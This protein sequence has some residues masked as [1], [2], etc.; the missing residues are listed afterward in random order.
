MVSRCRERLI[1]NTLYSQVLGVPQLKIRNRHTK[2]KKSKEMHKRNTF[3]H[4]LIVSLEMDLQ[5]FNGSEGKELPKGSCWNL[6]ESPDGLIL[7]TV[8]LEGIFKDHYSNYILICSVGLDS[9]EIC[10]SGR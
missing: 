9:E 8:Q 6:S 2:R 10:I 4:G 3:H 1:R 7:R 5:G